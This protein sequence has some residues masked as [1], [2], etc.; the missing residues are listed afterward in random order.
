MIGNKF[1]I[2][3]INLIF[4][5]TLSFS[6][7]NEICDKD[8]K[9]LIS[10]LKI[11]RQCLNDNICMKKDA[12][13]ND[14]FV[15]IKEILWKISKNLDSAIIANDDLCKNVPNARIFNFLKLK[16]CG[17]IFDIDVIE[18]KYLTNDIVSRLIISIIDIR[19]M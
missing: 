17:L 14:L 12:S 6:M 1:C 8:V 4:V 9:N 3:L 16:D 10:D 11:F 15:Q 13:V 5:V 7:I 2:N 18:D 19:Q